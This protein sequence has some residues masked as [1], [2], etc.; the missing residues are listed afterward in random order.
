[1]R[2]RCLAIRRVLLGR[3]GGTVECG[4]RRGPDQGWRLGIAAY[5]PAELRWYPTLRGLAAAR[6]RSSPGGRWPWC[7]SGRPTTGRPPGSARAWWW[8]S[9]STG[10]RPRRDRAGAQRGGADR[11]PGLAGGRPA[12]PGSRVRSTVPGARAAARRRLQRCRRRA[13]TAGRR[14]GSLARRA[15]MNSRSDSRFRYL[16]RQRAHGRAVRLDGRPGAALRPPHDR[17]GRVQ[18]RR[19]R[20]CHR[21]A[22]SCAARAAPRC[23]V[24]GLLQRG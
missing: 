16:R 10:E 20:G 1:M 15:R 18:Q 21:A 13:S 23:T 6:V 24:A 19:A 7:P 8:W 22:R 3:G 5:E 2:G 17:P 14:P 11:L 9:A 12:G 4:L